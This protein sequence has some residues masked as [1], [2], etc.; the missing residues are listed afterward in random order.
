LGGTGIYAFF[1]AVAF[2]FIYH[3]FPHEFTSIAICCCFIDTILFSVGKKDFLL[4]VFFPGSF[5]ERTGESPSTAAVC[6]STGARAKRIER[7]YIIHSVEY[8]QLFIFSICRGS[9]ML[10]PEMMPGRRRPGRQETTVRRPC[11][12]ESSFRDT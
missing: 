10:F 1:V 7:D 2:V 5:S 9:F 3:Y 11:S 8:V 4:M 6:R 12:R